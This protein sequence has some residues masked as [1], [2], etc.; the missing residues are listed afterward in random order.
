MRLRVRNGRRMVAGCYNVASGSPVMEPS[1]SHPVFSA[2]G[3]SLWQRLAV[4][5]GA[6]AL[7]WLAV[8]WAIA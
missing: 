8:L 4:A 5:G 3:A 1:P 2:L 7:L 6:A